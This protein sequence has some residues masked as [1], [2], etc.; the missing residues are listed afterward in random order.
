MPGSSPSRPLSSLGRTFLTVA[1]GAA[2]IR[3]VALIAATQPTVAD[4]PGAF[5][6]GGG[7]TDVNPEAAEQGE[8][9][10]EKIEAWQ[11]ARAQG[12]VG[13]ARPTGAAQFQRRDAHCHATYHSPPR[14]RCCPRPGT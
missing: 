11:Q 8:Q 2:F 10:Q 12:R 14:L 7:A 13:Q 6:R 5:A 1:A 3:S 4:R 9:A